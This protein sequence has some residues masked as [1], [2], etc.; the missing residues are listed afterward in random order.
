MNLREHFNDLAP[1]WDS[2]PGPP[3][4]GQRTACFVEKMN[5]SGARRVLDVG[6]GTGILVGPLT[7]TLAPA[8]TVVELDLADQML[9]ENLRTHAGTRLA[10]VCADAT[11]LPFAPGSFDVVLCFGVLPHL[12]ASE[13]V[14]RELLRVLRPG[15]RIGV[16]HL[17]DSTQLNALHAELGPPVADD[18]LPPADVL[19]RT[20]RRAGAARVVTE[21][22]PGWYF[23]CATTHAR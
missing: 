7:R 9:R 18:H 4:A 21:E 16:G 23:L 17:M 10:A 12:G 22:Q 14:I 3:D 6:C 11:S 8:A 2:L 5:V 20:F 13:L 1:R 15:G 19:G